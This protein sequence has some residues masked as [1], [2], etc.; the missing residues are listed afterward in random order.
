M[1]LTIKKKTSILENT[2]IQSQGVLTVQ[3]LLSRSSVFCCTRS[4]SICD[5]YSRPGG[6]LGGACGADIHCAT[7]KNFISHDQPN[8]CNRNIVVVS[9]N[10]RII[11]SWW[12]ETNKQSWVWN[13]L[14]TVQKVVF[15]ESFGS[16]W[17]EVYGTTPFVNNRP[18][19]QSMKA[20]NITYFAVQVELAP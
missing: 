6:Q 20:S 2:N 5:R 1:I 13:S 10:D 11:G 15:K 19:W 9:I 16:W 17:H 12:T 14:S 18:K 7:I 8:R 3:G 4:W